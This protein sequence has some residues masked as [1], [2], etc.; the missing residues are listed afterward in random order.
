MLQSLTRAYL[1]SHL[2]LKKQNNNL[3]TIIFTSLLKKR[4]EK[5][6]KNR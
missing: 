6:K 3:E 2:N 1:P 4:N 5:I